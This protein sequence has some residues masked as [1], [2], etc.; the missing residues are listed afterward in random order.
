M[1]LALYRKE[2]KEGVGYGS[3]IAWVGSVPRRQGGAVRY[4]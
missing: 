3:P 2:A 4:F 1:V